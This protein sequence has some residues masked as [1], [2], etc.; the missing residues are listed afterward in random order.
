MNDLPYADPARFVALPRVTGL[1]LSIDG[2]R[3]VVVVQEPDTKGARYSSALWQI[4]VDVGT[5]PVRLTRSEKG[6][7]GPAFRPDGS[8]L[9]V[10]GRPDPDGDGDDEEAS[11]WALPETGEPGVLARGPG[12]VGAPVVATGS[13]AVFVAGARLVDATDADDDRRRRT[14]RKDR[15]ITAILQTGMPIRY[16]DHELGDESPRLFEVDADDGSLRDLAPDAGVALTDAQY[17]V[18]ADGHTIATTW[19]RRRSAGRFPHGVCLVDVESGRRTILAEGEDVQFELPVIS[20]DGRRVAIRRMTDG[21]FDTPFDLG[22]EVHPADGLSE[23]VAVELGD[24]MPN[25]YVWSH[26]SRMLFVAG[27]WHGRGPINAVDPETGSVVR[28]LVVDAAYSNLCPSP[29]GRYLFALRSAIDAPPTPVRLDTALSDQQP[30]LLTTPAPTPPLPG[31]AIDVQTTVGDAVVRG[32]LCLPTPSSQPPPLMLWIHGGPFMSYNGWSWRW[33]PW[34]AV[35]NGY[36]VLLP[37]PALSTGYGPEFIARAWPHRAGLVWR[38]LEALLDDTLARPDVDGART[39]CLGGSF[40]GFMTNWIAGHTDRFDAIVTHAGLWALDQQHTTTDGAAWKSG[41]FGTPAEHPQWYAE[42]SPHN[43]VDSIRT[44]MLVVHG[45]R[46]YRVPISEALR[47]WWDLVSR[48]DGDPDDL[49]HRF[50][51]LT[52]ENHWVLSPANAQIW[53]ETVLGFCGLH[54][55]RSATGAG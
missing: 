32:W 20:P 21:D 19:R 34:V 55:A 3:L 37:D 50:L 26:D 5:P 18:S 6:E 54:L 27:D 31:R 49:P 38:D 16:W 43:F 44:P 1:A 24:L 17:S 30:V 28:R 9:F 11:L 47:L 2:S 42:N 10:S 15:K 36:A 40:G 35:A 22:L 51:Q 41:L 48:Y 53:Y 13:G 8:L 29:D 52:G 45:N 39:A 4:G 14:E 46:D 7:S 25:E 12:G 23:P 33:S